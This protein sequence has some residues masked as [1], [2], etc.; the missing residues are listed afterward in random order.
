MDDRKD[1]RVW[2]DYVAGEGVG[3]GVGWGILRGGDR[4]ECVIDDTLFLLKLAK[5]RKRFAPRCA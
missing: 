1:N 3:G 2:R 4:D 5:I